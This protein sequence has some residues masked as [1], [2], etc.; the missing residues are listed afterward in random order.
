MENK[1]EL[2]LL[3]D[4][5]PANLRI[6]KNV[7]AEKYAVATAPSAE[8]LFSLLKTSRP[9][10]ILLDI[11]MPD[12]N[13]YEAIRMLKSRKETKDI[14]VI[15][16]TGKTE[17]GDE[18]EG[19]SLGAMDYIT[20]PFQPPLLLKRIEVHLLVS[21]Q[22]K[23]LEKQ[24]AELQYY[25]SHLRRAFSTYLSEDVV[26]EIAANP[27][28]L[29][30]GGVKRRMSAMFTDVFNFTGIAEALSPEDLVDLLN[31]YFSVM[32]GAILEQ[33]GT[34]DKYE[35][36]AIV[37]F[38]GAPLEQ[39]DHAL[40]CCTAAA[41]MKRL[42]LEWNRKRILE[43]P[44]FA[45]VFTRIGINTGDMIAGNMGT[46]RKMNYTIMGNAVNLAARLERVNKL[47]KTGILASEDTIKECGNRLLVRRLDRIR[48]PGINEPVLIHEILELT[49]R[50]SEAAKRLADLFQAALGFFEKRD[51]KAAEAAFIHV[52]RY[53]PE[54]GPSHLYLDRCRF[55]R[56]TPPEDS[57]DGIF[58]FNE[59]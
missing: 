21:S 53:N 2:I 58:N 4:D 26:E 51:W 11:D 25:N 59:K 7:L 49:E 22:R 20:K 38:F 19:L 46:D 16:L 52:L 39:A 6:G 18:L 8:K 28:R 40:R 9:D 37:A 10:L 5:N 1:K 34:I 14:P 29:Q 3:V 33:K 23:T 55:Y 50:A 12:M 41:A 45:P 32:S 47:Y 35:G 43:R 42:E 30:L 44:G 15:F 31:R 13:G 57:W 48:V 56:E 54:D 24:A 17:S 36:D 27:A